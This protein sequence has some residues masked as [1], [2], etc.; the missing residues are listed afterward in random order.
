MNKPVAL[1]PPQ[2]GQT[3]YC[4]VF[5]DFLHQKPVELYADCHM[6]LEEH[7]FYVGDNVVASY[8]TNEVK[9]VLVL[10]TIK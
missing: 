9:S 8:H 6:Q 4:V 7:Q 10:A 1:P 2:K 5:H 3:R